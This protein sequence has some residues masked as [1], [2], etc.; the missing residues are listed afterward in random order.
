MRSLP[1]SLMALLLLGLCVSGAQAQGWGLTRE[2]PR[3]GHHPGVHSRP[4]VPTPRDP[5][6]RREEM[7]R[8]YRAILASQPGE[9]MAF[10]HLLTLV[11][12]RDG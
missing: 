7:I 9:D 10:S 5:S 2:H 6:A 1:A 11:R 12:E 8:R 4:H 3:P